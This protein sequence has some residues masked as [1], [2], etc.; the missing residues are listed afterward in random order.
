MPFKIEGDG[1]FRGEVRILIKCEKCGRTHY[2]D[3]ECD[4]LD[5]TLYNVQG[6]LFGEEQNQDKEIDKNSD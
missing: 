3:L 2:S 4:S 1:E 5:L 6:D